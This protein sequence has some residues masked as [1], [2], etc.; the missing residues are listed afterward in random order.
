MSRRCELTGKGP[1][2]KNLVSHS[3]I[4]TKK[5]VTP[6]IHKKRMFSETLNGFVTLRISTSALRSIQ[7][8]GS[9]DTFV[10]RQSPESMSKRALT[11]QNRIKK[12]RAAR[13]GHA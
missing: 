13:D 4:K 6:N 11:V 2:V 1:L 5:W 3:N 10:L 12:V 8:V 9:F 7:H